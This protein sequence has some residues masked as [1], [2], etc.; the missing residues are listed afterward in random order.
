[1]TQAANLA[2]AFRSDVLALV[3]EAIRRVSSSARDR[4]IALESRLF[5]DLA[6]DS[7]DL[8]AVI[9]HL[10]DH[11][12]VEIDPDEIPSMRLVQDLV[13]SLTNR[14]RSAA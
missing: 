4:T 10:Q 8:V 6:L 12:G 13:A 14:L 2:G 7:L 1:M 11:F 3:A 9:L 5:E